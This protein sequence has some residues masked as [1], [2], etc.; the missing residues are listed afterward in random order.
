MVQRL[1]ARAHVQRVQVCGHGLDALARQGQHQARAVALQAG[2][3]VSMPEPFGQ[4]RNVALELL[5]SF[6][7]ASSS[8][9]V[10]AKY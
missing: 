1:V 2:V 5:E 6:H 3:A 8:I 9:P 4:V 7:N 10:E